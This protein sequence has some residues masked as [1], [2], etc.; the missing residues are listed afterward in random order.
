MKREKISL[1]SEKR[2]REAARIAG[3]AVLL[4]AALCVAFALWLRAEFRTPGSAWARQPVLLRIHL[5]LW[6]EP[7]ANF[8]PL[9]ARRDP[10]SALPLLRLQAP[11]EILLHERQK[12]VVS[13]AEAGAY[14]LPATA[15]QIMGRGNSTWEGKQKRPYQLRFDAPVGLLGMGAARKWILL[16]DALDKSL[17]RPVIAHKIGEFIG[18]DWVPAIRPVELEING[19]YWG[20]CLLTEKV[21]VS[22]ERLAL[23]AGSVL[24]RADVRADPSASWALG[25]GVR[26]EPES[27][28]WG[29]MNDDARN[30]IQQ[31]LSA[32]D[33]AVYHGNPGAWMEYFDL[34]ALVNWFLLEE[35]CNNL[36]S[37]L[38]ASVYFSLSPE[39]KLRFCTIWDF[40]LSMANT[41]VQGLPAYTGWAT[42]LNGR[43]WFAN[44]TQRPEFMA[45]VQARYAELVAQGVYAQIDAWITEAA[46]TLAVPQRTNYQAWP[47]T[48]DLP[49]EVYFTGDWEENVQ[50]VRD[51]FVQRRAWLDGELAEDG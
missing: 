46:D 11:P 44:L 45:L 5:L 47:I 15:M 12:G 41:G 19:S 13:V 25:Q 28:A 26:I 42:A 16:A 31:Q 6:G 18:I 9:P 36:D 50:Y 24:L 10:A 32:I 4:L 40:D 27:P 48:E 2:K 3:V 37:A 49:L 39:G 51:Y 30:R 29:E 21:E 20:V 14:D 23:P 1:K 7:S 43:G 35:L 17:L 22:P 34:D 38:M 33:E 8:E